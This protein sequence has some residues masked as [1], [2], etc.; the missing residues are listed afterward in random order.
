MV[1][2]E[3]EKGLKLTFS[4]S[5]GKESLSW[6]ISPTGF[7]NA[8]E[9]FGLKTHRHLSQTMRVAGYSLTFS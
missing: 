2:T 3:G 5:R 4:F 1:D 8:L 7:A 9:E 6:T